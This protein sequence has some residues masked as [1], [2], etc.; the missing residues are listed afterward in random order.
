[1]GALLAR[2][3]AAGALGPGEHGSTFGG[4]PFVATIAHAVL[5][6][7][8]EP[9]FLDAVAGKGERLGASLGALAAEHAEVVAGARGRGLMWGLVLRE[10]RAPELVE[11][12]QAAGLLTLTAG[13]EVL[14]LLPPLSITASE[15]DEATALIAGG[16]ARLA[17]GGRES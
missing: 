4:G 6:V 2:G 5:D 1:M 10:P 12:L 16:L 11:L 13:K 14:R 8:L 7:I 15:I 3:D 9:R 17:R